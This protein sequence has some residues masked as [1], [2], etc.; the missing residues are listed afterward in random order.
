M[1]TKLATETKLWQRYYVFSNAHLLHPYTNFLFIKNNTQF[2]R[3]HDPTHLIIIFFR[4][5]EN[6]YKY[7]KFD[8]TLREKVTFLWWLLIT[9]FTVIILQS[10]GALKKKVLYSLMDC[11]LWLT[12][13]PN[14]WTLWLQLEVYSSQDKSWWQRKTY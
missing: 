8:K 5:N 3:N 6:K 10:I 13:F 14:Q 1:F 11:E 9:C 4:E 2:K 12:H 7:S